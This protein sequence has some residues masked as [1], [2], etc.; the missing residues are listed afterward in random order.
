MDNQIYLMAKPTRIT[1]GISSTA[2]SITVAELVTIAGDAITSADVGDGIEAVLAPK[3]SKKRERILITAISGNILTVS[4]GGLG[5][6]PYTFSGTGF[7]HSTGTQLIISNTSGFYDG[8]PNKTNEEFISE[9]W[10]VDADTPMQYDAEPSFTSASNQFATVKLVEDTA[11]AGAADASTVQKGLS[12]EATEAEIDADTATGSAA[13]LYVN[14]S[15]LASSKYGTRLPSAD[16]KTLLND[17]T[18]SATEINQLDG[19]T[20]TAAQLTEAG[21]FFGST[22]ISAAEAETL[23]DGSDADSLHVHPSLRPSYTY[24]VEWDENTSGAP[25]TSF[26]GCSDASTQ[27]VRFG[28]GLLGDTDDFFSKGYKV[29]SSKPFVSD[30]GYDYYNGSGINSYA[31]VVEIGSDVWISAFDGSDV[32][33]KNG[34]GATFSGTTG[35]GP[36]GHDP[37]NSYLLVLDTSTTIHRYSGISGTTITYVDEITL[38]TGISTSKGF[39]FDNT[40]SQYIGIDTANSV[41]R[42]FNSSGTTVSTTAYSTFVG[43]ATPLGVVLVGSTIYLVVSV[44]VDHENDRGGGNYT[45]YTEYSL[46]PTTLTV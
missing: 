22:D 12:E 44:V 26:V 2:T 16:Q 36:L 29:I 34:S 15:T 3:S 32:I 35:N 11:N 38:D 30:V 33:L 37:T 20:I 14:P 13:R 18:A 23:T 21:T 27:T 45:S 6:A 46:V 24:R 40:N 31:G 9:V 43:T 25:G 41:V 1:A 39:V 5:E 19:A 7:A 8:F 4:R 17:I 28:Q 10:T 42:I